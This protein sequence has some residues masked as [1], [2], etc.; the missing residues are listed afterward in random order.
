MNL[1]IKINDFNLNYIKFLE[2]KQ[3][4]IINGNFSKILYLDENVSFNGIYIACS[5]I[6][7]NTVYFNEYYNMYFINKQSSYFFECEKYNCLSIFTKTP[8]T[9]RELCKNTLQCVTPSNTILKLT[10]NVY[11]TKLPYKAP[12]YKTYNNDLNEKMYLYN[13]NITQKLIDIEYQIIQYYK[14]IY[15]IQKIGIY[16]LKKQIQNGYLKI[17]KRCLI[18]NSENKTNTH[19]SM[20]RLNA[21]FF[22]K[23]TQLLS[24][25]IPY[26]FYSL[27]KNTEENFHNKEQQF[28][29]KISGIWENSTNIGIT[30]KIIEA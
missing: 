29:L 9:P 12:I 28:I 8:S 10:N 27:D 6:L 26:S 3:N 11:E 16:S 20:N 21:N 24:D 25:I 13:L 14:E 19:I 1:V 17:Y 7:K 15:N 23:N 5:L 4:N 2:I 22:E 30:Y 18:N